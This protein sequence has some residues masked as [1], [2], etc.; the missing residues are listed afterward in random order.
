MAAPLSGCSREGAAVV[1]QP[2]GTKGPE[3]CWCSWMVL[4][5]SLMSSCIF[6]GLLMDFGVLDMLSVAMRKLQ[7]ADRLA[8]TP[9]AE[10]AG[11]CS[12]MV[13]GYSQQEV[14]DA[15][16]STNWQKAMLVKT[17][18]SCIL[19]GTEKLTWGSLSQLVQ[20]SLTR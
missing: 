18:C 20:Q 5:G 6:A 19:T 11:A 3:K 12:S 2:L 14:V 13:S 17:L 1:M 7:R 10:G 8:A 9:A 4:A 15:G 16:M